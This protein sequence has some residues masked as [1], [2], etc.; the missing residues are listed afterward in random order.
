MTLVILGGGESGT[1]AALLAKRKGI[2]VF[3]SDARS[4]ADKYKRLLIAN[5][6]PFEEHGHRHLNDIDRISEVIKSPGVPN[7][8]DIIIELSAVHIPII[9]EIEFAARFI[10]KK[11]KIIAITGTNGKSTTSHLIYHLLNAAGLSVVLAGNMGYSLAKA[12]AETENPADYYVLELSSAQLKHLTNFKANIAC[13]TNITADHLDRYDHSMELY[14]NA[15]FSILRNMTSSDHFIYNIDDEIIQAYLSKNQVTPAAY[16]ITTNSTASVASIFTSEQSLHVT[17]GNQ[18][19]SFAKSLLTITGAHNEYN[20]MTAITAAL[21]IGVPATTISAALP[22]FN[23]LPHRIEWCGAP[24]GI[25]CYND[26]HATNVASAAVALTRFDAPIIWI[27]GGVD[28]GNDYSELIPIVAKKVKAIVCLG[29][30]NSKII[31]AFSHLGIS[32]QQ[33]NSIDCALSA[34]FTVAIS[35]PRS[36]IL[37]SPA[38]ASFD[39]FR[40]AADRGNQFREKVKEIMLKSESPME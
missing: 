33:T 24:Q 14:A 15:K 22:T 6:I 9:D 3:L 11:S 25:H 30:D 28:K 37:L 27:A 20:A 16:A 17:V 18:S 19:F 34:A 21:I 4:I 26:S 31:N 12:L 40:N 23:G 5:E 1:G 8:S 36:V 13:L 7:S 29:K 10:G 32:I 35:T 2:D 38:C 39:L